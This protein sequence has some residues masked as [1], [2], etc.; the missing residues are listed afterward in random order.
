MSRVNV[1]RIFVEIVRRE[2]GELS[3]V[4]GRAQPTVNRLLFV[5][6]ALAE[7]AM[8]RARPTSGDCV[9]EIR[10]RRLFGVDRFDQLFY[11]LRDADARTM[12]GQR[13][14]RPQQNVL[15]VDCCVAALEA[16]HSL[17]D[18]RPPDVQRRR[19]QATRP[20]RPLVSV[21]TASA[22]K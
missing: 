1:W 13:E 14:P 11:V 22:L 2:F 19:F 18:R 9:V 3:I 7:H 4:A 21:Q 6:P 20:L 12:A 5:R 16:G 8:S 15:V 10:R 17:D